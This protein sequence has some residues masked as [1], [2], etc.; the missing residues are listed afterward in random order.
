[1]FFLDGGGIQNTDTAAY[2]AATSVAFL[3]DN[4]TI[5]TKAFY[6]CESLRSVTIPKGCTSIGDMA[7]YG[8]T[9]LTSITIPEGVTSIGTQ[10]FRMCRGLTSITIP[11]SMTSIG[12]GAFLN[13]SKLTDVYYAGSEDQWNQINIIGSVNHY[14]QSATKHYNYGVTETGGKT[15]LSG[16]FSDAGYTTPS[17]GDSDKTYA[18][19]VDSDILTVKWQI[20]GGTNATSASTNLR[21]FTSVDSLN[22]Q[23]VGFII[24]RASGEEQ[25]YTSTSVYTQISGWKDGETQPISPTVFSPDSQYFYSCRFDNIPQEDFYTDFTVTP[26]WTTLDGTKVTGET[27]TFKISDANGFTN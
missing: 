19:Y 2:A 17:T 1:M 25:T 8:C 4:V 15:I 16:W 22:Y 14:L 26:F 5:G 7:F 11:A 27:R 23:N 21:L 9:G 24:K 6:Y 10:T 20:S 3:N 18:K 12:D 13:A